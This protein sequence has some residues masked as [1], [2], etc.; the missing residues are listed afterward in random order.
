MNIS[1][2]KEVQIHG[3]S[4]Y[5]KIEFGRSNF[6]TKFVRKFNYP[7]S[8]DVRMFCHPKVFNSLRIEKNKET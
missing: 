4:W 5:I 8:G 1:K 6:R 3:S 7:K 2:W